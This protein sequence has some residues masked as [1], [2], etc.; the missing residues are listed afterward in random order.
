MRWKI[1]FGI[2][3]WTL[4]NRNSIP[5]W[6]EFVAVDISFVL[7]TNTCRGVLN[8][9]KRFQDLQPKGGQLS[10]T[11]FFSSNHDHDDVFIYALSCHRRYEIFYLSMSL[12]MI[13]GDSA[14]R[15]L[16]NYWWVFK[17]NG[18]QSSRSS[19]NKKNLQ[20]LVHFNGISHQKWQRVQTN[21]DLKFRLYLR[22]RFFSP[23]Y[24]C[25]TRFNALNFF[26]F[27]FVSDRT[28]IYI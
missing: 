5:E 15:I 20:T 4:L 22:D 25:S 13:S 18:L 26:F 19:R 9:T 27:F 7:D 16:K 6:V 3:L 28:G 14:K 10:P 21:L 11:A 24:L 12:I 2:S 1:K 23:N 8:C 17:K